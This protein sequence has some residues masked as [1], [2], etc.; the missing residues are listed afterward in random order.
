MTMDSVTYDNSEK[1]GEPNTASKSKIGRRITC[2][3][4]NECRLKKICKTT[5]SIIF[6]Q[7]PFFLFSSFSNSQTVIKTLVVVAKKYPSKKL[8]GYTLQKRKGRSK[9]YNGGKDKMFQIHFSVDE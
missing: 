2:K 5:D 6:I 3:K 9:F 7:K 1:E 4:E 8:S